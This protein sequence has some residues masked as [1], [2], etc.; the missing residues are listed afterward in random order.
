M[1]YCVIGIETVRYT[2]KDGK[3][4]NGV[5]LHLTFEN[6]KTDGLCCDSVYMKTDVAKGVNVGDV[7]RIFYNKY[8]RVEFVNVN[9]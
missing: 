6:P 7:V 9:G 5:R 8:G 1:D 3:E 4:V 2:N